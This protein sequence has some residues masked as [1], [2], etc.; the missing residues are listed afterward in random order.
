M[1]N[2]LDST[3]T[4]VLNDA[5]AP[6]LQDLR[7]AD[8]SFETPDRTFTP[9]PGD[10]E[11]V[12][13]RGPGEPQPARPAADRRERSARNRFVRRQPPA[14]GGLLVHRHDLGSRRRRAGPRRRRAPAARPGADVAQPLPDD[15]RPSTSRA[16][17]ARRSASTRRRR[18]SPSST[19]TRTPATS[20]PPSAS[21][22]RPAF[23]L[24]V[25]VELSLDPAG[26]DGRPRHDALHRLLR[27]RRRPICRG[28]RS[29]GASST[30][31]R[32]RASPKRWST[33]S[34]SASAPDP[35]SRAAT[36]SPVCRRARTRSAS[37]RAGSRSTPSRWSCPDGRRTTS[38]N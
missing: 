2:D 11:P 34:T 29:A 13:L 10:R 23:Y 31:R 9:G 19:R 38:S 22:P 33:S 26:V 17:S 37:S 30:S 6:E 14:A 25:T 1:F 28:F 36:R 32:G 3:L 8:V 12:P 35:E 16:S 24:T 18:W 21:P 20:G 15:P 4:Q 7:D 27:Q 5:P